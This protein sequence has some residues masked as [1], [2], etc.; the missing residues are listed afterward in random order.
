MIVATGLGFAYDEASPLALSDRDI[1]LAAGESV[2]IHGPSGSGKSTLLRLLAG[3]APWHAGGIASGDASVAGHDLREPRVDLADAVG[4]VAQDVEGGGVAERVLDEV[5]FTLENLGV[6]SDE[7][8]VRARRAL[9]AVD[10]GHLADRRLATL[11]GGERQRVAIAGAL[12]ADPAVLI[13][14]EPLSQLDHAGTAQLIALL[15]RM[16]GNRTTL[17]AEHRL[18]GLRPIVDRAICFGDPGPASGALRATPNVTAGAQQIVVED[19]RVVIDGHTLSEV[20]GL[21][22]REGSVVAL[23]GPNGSGKSTLLRALIGAHPDA[24]GLLRVAGEDP[25]TRPTGLGRAVGYLPQRVDRIFCR[26]TVADEIAFT[27]RCRNADL[28]GIDAHLERFGLAALKD[29]SPRRLSAGQRL[30][31]ALA[32]I[33][34]GNPPIVLLDEPTRGLDDA[35]R[36]ILASFL[37]EH[38]ARG[39]C[40]IVATHDDGLAGLA[41]QTLTLESR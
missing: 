40:A 3:I 1:D 21:R 31:V 41:D 37:H 12:A 22:V 10:A 16:R 18:E 4:W 23:V 29:R 13:L 19:F 26:A 30:R 7:I 8:G 35:A 36:E 27:L 38:R 33:T 20:S 34:A 39:G 5:A 11:S 17:I 14:D 2:L 9:D 6:D 28:T 25:R 32:A 24:T 15:E